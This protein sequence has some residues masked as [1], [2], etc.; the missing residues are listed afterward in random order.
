[1]QAKK[2]LRNE[3]GDVII[4]VL[5][6][7]GLLAVT[8]STLTVYSVNQANYINQ[9]RESYQM[10]AGAESLAKVAA[11][12]RDLAKRRL[13]QLGINEDA[14]TPAEVVA[15]YNALPATPG[16]NDCDGVAGNAV[17]QE[18]GGVFFCLDNAVGEICIDRPDL[19]NEQLC[20]ELD[21]NA[22]NDG[23]IRMIFPEL[24]PK[25]NWHKS[26]EM[27]AK[28]FDFGKRSPKDTS[29]ILNQHQNSGLQMV[30]SLLNEKANDLELLNVAYAGGAITTYYNLPMPPPDISDSRTREEHMT[31][32]AL[33]LDEAVTII[34]ANDTRILSEASATQLRDFMETVMDSSY[35]SDFSGI[36][37]FGMVKSNLSGYLNLLSHGY[38]PDAT[39]VL[40][41]IRT[42]KLPY[43]TSVSAEAADFGGGESSQPPPLPP[44][45]PPSDGTYAQVIEA[46][47]VPGVPKAN[48]DQIDRCVQVE[49]VSR[50]GAD[51]GRSFMQNVFVQ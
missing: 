43:I 24:N 12:S 11:K 33:Y 45:S 36:G 16:L 47:R 35:A 6:V 4:L 44:G 49:A 34:E 28:L 23:K 14:L 32:I 27:V 50:A 3:K 2:L 19:A 46:G 10:M 25:S 9:V 39:S 13:L 51:E 1:M 18:R 41:Y 48:C 7:A 40:D 26:G 21:F 29:N 30:A 17:L 5:I 38:I 22:M 31:E 8:L 42:S 20:A 37:G 15:A